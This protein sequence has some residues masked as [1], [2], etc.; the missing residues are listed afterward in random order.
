MHT[1]VTER[2]SSCPGPPR[3]MGHES[4]PVQGERN[5]RSQ[6]IPVSGWPV[7]RTGGVVQPETYARSGKFWN[8]S[9]CCGEEA[10][11]SCPRSGPVEGVWG[12]REV[13]PACAGPVEQE[14]TAQHAQRAPSS[15]FAPPSVR[16]PRRPSYEPLTSSSTT[17]RSM[18]AKLFA[19]RGVR[20]NPSEMN[21]GFPRL[22]AFQSA[23]TRLGQR[24]A[25]WRIAELICA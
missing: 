15:T 5:I 11:A 8:L 3:P 1:F 9:T 12:N 17:G 7:D 2:E 4:A 20:C 19:P 25:A 6:V 24:C 21:H 10:N 13:P 14:H 16:G 18:R 22:R 23:T